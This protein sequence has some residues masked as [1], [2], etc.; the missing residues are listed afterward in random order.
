MTPPTVSA[1]EGS[2]PAAEGDQRGTLS[3]NTRLKCETLESGL[4]R[5]TFI[6]DRVATRCTPH[7]AEVKCAVVA[8]AALYRR[9]SDDFGVHDAPVAVGA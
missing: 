2:A 7:F 6:V 9:V 5:H 1:V 4:L 8:V 3:Q